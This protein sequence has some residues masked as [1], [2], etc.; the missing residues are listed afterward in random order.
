MA[1]V[2][3]IV[4]SHSGAIHVESEPGQG[5]TV[6][7]MFPASEI[8]SSPEPRPSSP[9]PERAPGGTILLVDDEAVI[10]VTTS[11]I[12][13]QLGYDVITAID[14]VAAVQTFR[15]QADHIVCVLLDLTMPRMGGE[16]ALNE[17]RKIRSDIPVLLSSGFNEQEVTQL[18]TGQ[19]NAGFIQKPFR[20]AQL[21][22]ALQ[23]V[24]AL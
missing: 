18:F 12:L 15:E 9:T 11:K 24:M 1:A 6:R 10:R 4:R 3:G 2:L 17:L 5:T 19:R 14:G 13:E 20:V 22:E 16:E 23:K 21:A 7:V 8:K